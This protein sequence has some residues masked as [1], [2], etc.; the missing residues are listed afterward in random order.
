MCSQG[1]FPFHQGAPSCS[2]PQ[3]QDDQH[4]NENL[5]L[6][7]G[8]WKRELSSM[9]PF[10]YKHLPWAE[11]YSLQVLRLPMQQT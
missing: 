11:Q 5:Q 8:K 7:S 2:F 3:T 10:T 4:L 6:N 9:L 1:M